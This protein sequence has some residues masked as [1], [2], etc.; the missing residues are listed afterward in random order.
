M[1]LPASVANKRLTAE[2]S[3]LDATFTINRGGCYG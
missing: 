1:D 2:L 3:S